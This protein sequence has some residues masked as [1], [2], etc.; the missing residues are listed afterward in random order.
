VL[1]VWLPHPSFVYSGNLKKHNMTKT[2]VL[3]TEHPEKDKTKIEFVKVLSGLY[4]LEEADSSGTPKDHNYIELV[5]KG[6]AQGM[7]L[8][9]AY[10]NPDKRKD[11]ILY[12]G[13]WND[14][15]V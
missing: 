11:G 1:F 7:D 15:I 9:F 14:G 12:I 13:Y 3:G 2:I 6:Y 8:M 10:N 4:E 5:S